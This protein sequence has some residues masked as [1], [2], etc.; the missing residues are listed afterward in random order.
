[1]KLLVV[2]VLATILCFETLI[3]CDNSSPLKQDQQKLFVVLV[4]RSD[5]SGS[6]GGA[7]RVLPPI[8]KVACALAPGDQFAVICIDE[9]GFDEE[10]R[11]PFEILDASREP[12]LSTFVLSFLDMK[13]EP[14]WPTLDEAR[15]LKL[16]NGTKGYFFDVNAS[17]KEK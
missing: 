3:G 8:N 9:Q 17:G 14:K 13:H 15:R 1:M 2:I 16:P 4:N 10:A 12:N 11:I 6:E 5:S 7:R